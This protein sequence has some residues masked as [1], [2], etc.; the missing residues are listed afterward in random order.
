MQALLGNKLQ[1]AVQ[2]LLERTLQGKLGTVAE[3]LGRRLRDALTDEMTR[4]LGKLLRSL[5]ASPDEQAAEEVGSK[6]PLDGARRP[7]A[8]RVKDFLRHSAKG[9]PG[10]LRRVSMAVVEAVDSLV[11]NVLDTVE[12]VAMQPSKKGGA[13]R[14]ARI[15]KKDRGQFQTV[16]FQVRACLRVRGCVHLCMRSWSDERLHGCGWTGGVKGLH[17]YPAACSVR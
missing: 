14:N 12:T 13:A 8:K 3:T 10:M 2:R 11:G 16:M 15:S 7:V 1:D 9:A 17:T 5:E 6:R 4:M